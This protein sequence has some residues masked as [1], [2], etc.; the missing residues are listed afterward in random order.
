[1]AEPVREPIPAASVPSTSALFENLPRE[2]RDRIYILCLISSSPIIVWSGFKAGVSPGDKKATAYQGQEVG[3]RT[4]VSYKAVDL[5]PNHD[6]VYDGKI[7]MLYIRDYAAK[8]MSLKNLAPGILQCNCAIASES[9]MVL[10]ANNTFSFIGNH[11]WDPIISWLTDIGP[12]HR[13]HLASLQARAKSPMQVEQD[14]NGTRTYPSRG[15]TGRGY[16]PLY[17][18]NPHLALQASIP[19]LGAVE[20]INPAIEDL[21][22]LLAN[23]NIGGSNICLS[24]TLDW[25]Y[26]AGFQWSDMDDPRPIIVV[27]P[28]PDHD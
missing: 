10:Y 11:N 17:P 28:E 16:E 7:Q 14:S 6:P 12:K 24:L 3:P 20:N 8:A 27:D 1:M 19:L 26:M 18:R 15:F 22:V 2:L 9:A 13:S 21:F 25:F 4:Y 5:D 23:Q